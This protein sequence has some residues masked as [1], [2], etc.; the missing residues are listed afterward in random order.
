[1]MKIINWVV[2]VGLYY[3]FLTTFSMGPSYLFL[4]RDRVMEEGTGKKIAATTGFITGQLMMFISIYYAPLHLALGRPHTITVLVLPYL[5]FHFFWN[6]H[7]NIFD[8]GSTTK[9][10]MRN[11][12][13]LCVFLNNLIFPLFNHFFLPS[14]TLCR[15]V[16]IYM[17]RCNNKML[18]V[19]SS[20]V[21]WLMG[22]IVFINCVEFVLFQIR[23]NHFIR[24]NKYL[25]SELQNSLARTFSIFL[26]ITCIFYLGR[27]P[28]PI[29]TNKLHN[30][31]SE[32][33]EKRESEEESY[34]ETTYQNKTEEPEEKRESEEES[35]LEITYQNKTE[36]PEE[37]DQELSEEEVEEVQFFELLE[38][39][40]KNKLDEFKER[41][42]Y[43][44]FLPIERSLHRKNE[45]QFWFE[46]PP[47]TFLFD[48]KRWNRPVRCMRYMK[49]F[50][51]GTAVPD[52]V[53]QYFFC[54]CSSDGKRKISFTYPPS[55]STF[56]EIMEQRISLYMPEKRYYENKD[57]YDHWVSTNE[58]KKY[59]LTNELI[60]RIKTF[61]KQ[62]ESLVLDVLEKKTRL[63]NDENGEGYLPKNYDPFLSGPYRAKAKFHS[64]SL[65]LKM[66]H[67]YKP[68]WN[69]IKTWINTIHGLLLRNPFIHFKSLPTY[70]N[71]SLNLTHPINDETL[72]NQFIA[73]KE[74]DKKVPPSYKLEELGLF[75]DEK[76]EEEENEDEIQEEYKKKTDY[77]FRSRKV[78]PV[79]I[80]TDR[81]QD[82]DTNNNDISD[83]DP[84]DDISSI[85][86]YTQ[87]SDFR[88]DLIKG[89]TR[90]QRRKTVTWEILQ[91]NMHS[92]LFLNQID[93]TFFF[94]FSEIRNFIFGNWMRKK[95][96]ILNLDGEKEE[97]KKNKKKK[98]SE[99]P[100]ILE[101]WDNIIFAQ[102]VRGLMLITQSIF[103]KYVALP[104]LI[105]AKNIGRILFLQSPEWYEDFR[106][107]NKEMHIKCTYNGVQLSET[108]FPKDWLMEGIQIKILFPFR[109][110]PWQ[111]ARVR[112]HDTLKKKNDFSF[113]TVWG[114][115]T[116]VLF[117]SP[118]KQSSFFEPIFKELKKKFIKTKKRG[119]LRI[120]KEKIKEFL[121][122]SNKKTKWIP[123]LIQVQKG[124]IKKLEKINPIFL[125]ELN[126]IKEYESIK[127]KKILIS[128]NKNSQELILGRQSKNWTNYSFVEKK[129]KDLVDRTITTRNQIK[130]IKKEKQKIILTSDGDIRSSN[131]TNLND[132]KQNI[133]QIFTRGNTRLVHKLH[134]FLKSFIERIYM[135]IFIYIIN[136][137]RIHIQIFFES[138]KKKINKSSYNDKINQE[139]LSIDE[140]KQKKMQFIL[141]IKKSF[142]NISDKNLNSY[143]DL[144]SLSQAYI[145]YKIS[146][147]QVSNKY[148]L[149][150]ILQYHNHGTL[151]FLK[152]RIKDSCETQGIFDS[153]SKHKKMDKSGMNEWK[154]WLKGHYQY[155]LSQSKWSLL[156]PQKW[157]K[158]VNEYCTVQNKDAIKGNSY[159]KD[160]YSLINYLKQKYDIMDSLIEQKEKWKK[161]YRYDLL[162]QKYISHNYINPPYIYGSPLKI[163]ENAEIPYLS[164]FDIGKPQ[165]SY[166]LMD[167]NISDYLGKESILYRKKNLERKFLNC[168]IFHFLNFLIRKNSNI[169][170]RTNIH[171]ISNKDILS[172]MIHKKIKTAK[173]NQ[174]KLVFDWMGMN[175]EKL[176]RHI[177]NLEPRF[178]PEFKILYDTYNAYKIKPWIIPIKL[179]LLRS[180]VNENISQNKNTNGNQKKYPYILSNKKGDLELKKGKKQEKKQQSGQVNPESQAQDRKKIKD[181]EKDYTGLHIKKNNK[182]KRENELESVLQKYL[183]FQL[184]WYYSF[185]TEINKNI[186]V[187]CLLLK[188][189]NPK[190]IAISSIKR[191]EMNLDIILME[192]DLS[193][194]E[195]IKRGI[196]IIEP[197]R[198]SIKWD[199][200]LIMYQIMGISLINKNKYQINR[201]DIKKIYVNTN[202]FEKSI[203]ERDHSMFINEKRNHYGFLVPEQ[204][205]STRHR[206]KFRILNSF[207]SWNRNVVN[208]I[209]LFGNENSV[210]NCEQFLNEDKYPHTNINNLIKLKLFIWPNYRLEDL[211]CMN[212]YWFNTNNGSR[213]TMSRIDMYPRFKM[214]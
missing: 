152:N 48:F 31:I 194:R 132:K 162:L 139:E 10:V 204:I 86:H 44:D 123:K 101:I 150:S 159:K 73:I 195:L 62:T 14:S 83:N 56:S 158:K 113:L 9:N 45:N 88:R 126:K 205:L 82:M 191:S 177:S 13:I 172:F 134:Y 208:E 206:R 21:G 54:T 198:L 22:H 133:W 85:R 17:F 167:I 196:M 7:K 199:K 90:A 116:E 160:K 67:A 193:V 192:R 151:L 183:L 214:N 47:L 118:R 140:I 179:L 97:T 11:L 128:S 94:D 43:Q 30:E 112:S 42:I 144:S 153:K 27:M 51:Y 188:I 98:E 50:Q 143:F 69:S 91:V 210:K 201:K 89:S 28:L 170:T 38:Q 173:P 61:E 84:T 184:R 102:P 180:D 185:P 157:R 87:Q 111:G 25:L 23:Q 95:S 33:E 72:L 137:L 145:F 55:L 100:I 138:I 141:A 148:N 52:E 186:W 6:N 36:E 211:A 76:E 209:S 120:L 58:Q 135:D 57:L 26:F 32:P 79:V 121:I 142:C 96:E 169:D 74:I 68:K 77:F 181:I 105:I 59:N 146:Q 4:L 115:E 175:Q 190:K 70:V 1:M 40:I 168:Q 65:T 24:S 156:V 213:F 60:N 176:N 35:Y 147:T 63:Y 99:E 136:M 166:P 109:L 71:D 164:N 189:V 80:Y 182:N 16:N 107:W 103:R 12:S 66:D 119:F 149:R 129:M 124:T 41:M 202:Y 93:K 154:N 46:K 117:G 81:D 64:L 37:Y 20:F 15:L 155:N 29:V 78:K 207:N 75:E 187:Y 212:R 49:N 171:K 34:L 8:Y 5:L 178:F 3:G 122:T 104:F 130:Q 200:K 108:E 165:L 53:S 2:V 125:F 39:L 163:N 197:F 203:A 92:P 161:N 131:N 127:N 18:F 114:M 174:R 19:T 110:K 106:D